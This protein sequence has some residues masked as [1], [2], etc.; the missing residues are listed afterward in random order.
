MVFDTTASNTGHESG[1]CVSIQRD[2]GRSFL[3]LACR[4]HVAEVVL[5]RVWNALEIEDSVGPETTMFKKFKKNWTSIIC[6]D[7][8]ITNLFTYPGDGSVTG[9]AEL[10]KSVLQNSLPRNDYQELVDL[11]LHY[12]GIQDEEK[13]FK[14]KTTGA[15][16]KA[17]WMIYALKIIM[18]HKRIECKLPEVAVFH[19]CSWRS[20]SVL[21]IFAFS[22]LPWWLTVPLATSA[23]QNDFSF[24]MNCVNFFN[25]DEVCSNAALKAMKNHIWYLN[26]ELVALSHFSSNVE[27]NIREKIARKLL[28]VEKR[29]RII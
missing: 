11:A 25:Q 2:V 7:D 18:L 10:Y 3:W 9:I 26:E 4:Y 15:L 6:K 21:L 23:P 28:S 22:S 12:L 27:E 1:A 8:Y 14:L 16:H 13:T 29:V 19:S 24:I 17:R 5:S 20:C